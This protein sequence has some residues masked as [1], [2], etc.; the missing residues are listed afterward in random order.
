MSI[1]SIVVFILRD[2]SVDVDGAGAEN[3]GGDYSSF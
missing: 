3:E 1:E 2:W